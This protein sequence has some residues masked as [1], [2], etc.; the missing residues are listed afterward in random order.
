MKPIN[1]A[2]VIRDRIN[3]LAAADDP[4]GQKRALADAIGVHPSHMSRMLKGTASWPVER[5]VGAVEY[6]GLTIQEAF[7]DLATIYVIAEG[8]QQT[9]AQIYDLVSRFKNPAKAV[10]KLRQLKAIEEIDKLHFEKLMGD[11]D[12]L[13]QVLSKKAVTATNH[14]RNA[15]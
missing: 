4:R 5:Y 13:Y 3:D 10:E 8:D 2:K 9:M 1:H 7:G 14:A 11:I 12:F 6:L 15:Q